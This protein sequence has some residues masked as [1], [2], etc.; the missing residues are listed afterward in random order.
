LT[1][2]CITKCSVVIAVISCERSGCSSMSAQRATHGCVSRVPHH[3][4]GR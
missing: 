2:L 3:G 4:G 1:A